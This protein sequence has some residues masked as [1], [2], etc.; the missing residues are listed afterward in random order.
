MSAVEHETVECPNYGY[1]VGSYF[2]AAARVT[3]PYLLFVNSFSVIQAD[4]W[5]EKLRSAYGNDGVRLVG[6]T[7]SFESMA[8]TYLRKCFRQ[9]HSVIEAVTSLAKGVTLGL[10]LKILFPTFPNVH[11]RTNCFFVARKDFLA[12]KPVMMRTKLNAWLFE[13]GRNS[14]TRRLLKRGFR[15]A[16]VGIDGSSY[17]PDAWPQSG[18]FWQSRQENLL[19]QDN[20]TRAYQQGTPAFQS[21]R[22]MEAWNDFTALPG[23]KSAAGDARSTMPTTTGPVVSQ[24]FKRKR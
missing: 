16:I 2:Y 13:A 20:R 18:I 17:E 7:G 5:L 22:S 3:Q 1:D 23:N 11:V 24:L 8:S 10:A 15:V 14:M 19:I 6:A 21:Q 9:H 12:M 4:F